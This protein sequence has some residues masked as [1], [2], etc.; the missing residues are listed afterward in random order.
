MQSQNIDCQTE[1]W[2]HY[3][4]RRKTSL[5][6]LATDDLSIIGLRQ[7]E[8]ID[9]ILVRV[10]DDQISRGH[11]MG[12]PWSSIPHTTSSLSESPQR[13]VRRIDLRCWIL[14]WRLPQREKRETLWVTAN[15]LTTILIMKLKQIQFY[16][17]LNGF[18]NFIYRLPGGLLNT[19][20]FGQCI[21][22]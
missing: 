9:T 20:S 22:N 18:S 11:S 21:K 6:L 10:G 17:I 7:G 14:Y 2:V 12:P 1:A 5:S 3:W 16:I 4:S 8:N 19:Y 15:S 13:L